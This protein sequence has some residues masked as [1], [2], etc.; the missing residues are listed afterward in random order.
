MKYKL[1]VCL[2]LIS[3]SCL[4]QRIT[5][6]ITEEQI[7][8]KYLKNGAWRYRIF[9]K[10]WQT[11]IDSAIALN[12]S[13]AYLYQQKSM[14]Y[15]KQG[16]YELAM[17]ILDRAIEVDSASFIDYRAFVK[18]IFVKS[19]RDAIRDFE[20]SKKLK[21]DNGYVMDHSFHFYI[22]L[23]HLQLNEFEKAIENFDKSINISKKDGDKW[24]HPLDLLYIGI[25]HKELLQQNEAIHYFNWALNNYDGFSD[26]EYYKV[27]SLWKMGQKESAKLLFQKAEEDF[28]AGRTINEANSKYEIYPYQI[29]EMDFDALRTSE[30]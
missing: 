3:I 9:A 19:Y 29:S 12:P 13:I 24:V 27:L 2:A 4:S 30:L 11:Y 26:A 15:F 10:E 21:G 23:C 6:P 1:L 25:A 17:P 20:F 8:D 22:G 16:K 28:K 5:A 18:C 14:P 7:I